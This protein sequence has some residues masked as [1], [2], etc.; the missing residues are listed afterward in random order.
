MRPRPG[1]I[2]LAH[3]GVLFLD[4]LPEFE[5]RALEALREPL[6]TGTI[7]IARASGSTVFPADFQLI[8]AMN[9]CPCGW[10]GHASRPCNC[11]PERIDRYRAKLSGPLLDR[12]DLH[13]GLSAAVDGTC[14]HGLGG[15]SSEAVRTRVLQCREIQRARQGILNAALDTQGLAR[16]CVLER[17][18]QT[19]LVRAARRWAW[20]ARAVHRVLRV[21]RT[22][23]DLER[24][25]IV[26]IAHI[27]EAV[28]Y[29]LNE[30]G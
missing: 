20:S 3:H 29:R 28:Q 4:E 22:I 19:V 17:E 21:A 10:L 9:P 27:A 16:H 1:E 11:T 13:L 23:A 12:I 6:E 15:E 30:P 26:Q 18:A 14:L 2:S 5:R 7:S 24:A 25:D 8:A